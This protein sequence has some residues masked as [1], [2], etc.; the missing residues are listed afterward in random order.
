MRVRRCAI[1]YLEPRERL[2]FD[3]DGLLAGGDGTV[4]RQQWLAHA[5]HL[6][7]P[8]PIDAPA[9]E[10]LG[11]LSAALWVDA[12]CLAGWPEGVLDWLLARGLALAEAEG[13]SAI[14]DTRLREDYW[15]GP[16]AMFHRAGRWSG[17]DAAAATDAAGLATATGL[18]QHL[19]PPP[20][21]VAERCSE[22]G[23]LRL[24]RGQASD[25]DDLLGRRTT[26]RNFDPARA[27]PILLLARMLERTFSA[28]AQ[29]RLDTDTV[30]LKKGSPSG[31]GLHPIE[32]HL[33]VQR[34]EGLAPG[35]YH[36]H[37]LDHALEPLPAPAMPIPELAR[38][39]VAGQ[40]WFAGAQVLVVLAAR[41]GRCFWKYRQHPK[42]YRAVT[43]D[44]G[45][46]SQTLYLAATDLGLGA[47]VTCAINEVDIER[48][49]ALD[50]LGGAAL[51]VCGFG[52]RADAMHNAEFDPTGRTWATPMA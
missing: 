37:P 52:W 49:L 42:A 28:Q 33:L 9:R 19:G 24:P 10:C 14:A 45:H 11:Q 20:P 32:A 48:E 22:E 46:L 34:V 27:L 35:A 3:L 18:R 30:F 1:V 36:Y 29:W 51:A 13:Q 21:A 25:F 2:G 26:C 4:R 44:A 23:R 39:A 41:F 40:H 47:F 6:D 31:G 16:A 15:W 12:A 50:P 38:V 7:A 5:P 8:V 43:M 17:E